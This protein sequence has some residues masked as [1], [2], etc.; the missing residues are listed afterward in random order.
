MFIGKKFIPS[1]V[2]REFIRGWTI[3]W[4][5]RN[6]ALLQFTKD[7]P[8]RHRYRLFTCWVFYYSETSK[9]ICN[10][11][12]RTFVNFGWNQ[13]FYWMHWGGTPPSSKINIC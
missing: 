7:V 13:G 8:F 3:G 1:F 12:P 4:D 5:W 2:R 11:E 6:G 10:K 9:N